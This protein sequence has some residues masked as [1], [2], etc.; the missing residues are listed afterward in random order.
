MT[1]NGV[2]AL[3]LLYCTEFDSYYITAIEDRPTLSVEYLLPL[4]ATIDPPCSTVSLR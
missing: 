2:I 4:L 3:I 1:L